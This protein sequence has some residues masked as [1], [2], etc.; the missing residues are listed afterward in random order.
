[1]AE[2]YVKQY[3]MENPGKSKEVQRNLKYKEKYHRLRKTIKNIVF[4]SCIKKL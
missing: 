2:S 3:Y 1:M 4:V